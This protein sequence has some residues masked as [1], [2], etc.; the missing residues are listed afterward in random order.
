MITYTGYVDV[1]L[2]GQMERIHQARYTYSGQPTAAQLFFSQLRS[3]LERRGDVEFLSREH[4]TVALPHSSADSFHM[5]GGLDTD[6]AELGVLRGGRAEPLV[7]I[8]YPHLDGLW[9]MSA[10]AFDAMVAETAAG[11]TTA[12]AELAAA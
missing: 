6:H 8:P 12:A 11:I 5:V 4:F 9:R 3:E 7:T 1:Y 2:D 10:E